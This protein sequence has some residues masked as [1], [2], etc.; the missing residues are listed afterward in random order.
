MK[1]FNDNV[2]IKTYGISQNPYTKDYI[3]VLQNRYYEEYCENCIKEY[4]D[5]TYKWCKPCQLKNNQSSGNIE[6]DNFIQKLQLEISNPWDMLFEWISYNQ[7]NKVKEISKSDFATTYLAL[8]KDGHYN[9]YTR[10]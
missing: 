2:L 9:Y 7:F 1:I 4:T 8:W 5:I 10:N 6:I 3:I